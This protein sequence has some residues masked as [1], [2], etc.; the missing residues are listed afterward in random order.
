[1]VA[2]QAG[3]MAAIMRAEQLHG[4]AEIAVDCSRTDAEQ[5]AD[6]LRVLQLGNEPEAVP[7]TR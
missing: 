1:M 3:S 2:Q 5:V 7:L 6:L 4:L